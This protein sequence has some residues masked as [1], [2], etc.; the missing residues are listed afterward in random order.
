MRRASEAEQR[1]RRR[2]RVFV[3]GGITAVGVLVVVAWALRANLRPEPA[4]VATAVRGASGRPAAPAPRPQI[5][6]VADQG[7]AHV[8]PGAPHPPYNSNPPTSGWHY[9][10][11]AAW[12]FHNAELPDELIVHNL[13]HGG[14]WISYKDAEDAEVVDALVGLSREYRTK[15]IIT[16][17]PR[18]DSRIAVAAWGHLMKLDRFDRAAIVNFI[19]RFKNKGPEFVPD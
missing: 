8:L 3:Y 9:A 5:V 11:T 16:H 10:T 17:R 6:K 12:G 2:R 13:E 4:A 19:A 14:I 18:N 15:V 1:E 7:R